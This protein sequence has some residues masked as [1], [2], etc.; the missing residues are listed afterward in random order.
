MQVKSL[1]HVNIRTKDV[2][3]TAR[4]Y[5]DVLCLEPRDHPPF[6]ADQVQ[7]MHDVQGRP[8]IH[9]Y[10]LEYELGDNG[11]VH[12]VAFDCAGKAELIDRLNAKSVPF[13]H[14]E[15]AEEGWSS[16]Y[17]N[18]PHGLMLELYFNGE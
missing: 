7:W 16:V 13:Q 17:V 5:A 2:P 6:T 18:D 10:G 4:F 15:N 14:R 9:I 3:G 8:I 11:P 1:D 12:H